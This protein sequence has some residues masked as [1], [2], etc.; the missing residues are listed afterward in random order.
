MILADT[1]V[2]L[3]PA[4]DI[5]CFFNSTLS[6]TDRIAPGWDKQ[7]GAVWLC[8]TDVAGL[9][10]IG[11]LCR[12]VKTAGRWQFSLHSREHVAKATRDDG[13]RL[14]LFPGRQIISSER[15][16][17]LALNTYWTVPDRVHSL[18][19]LVKASL[20]A[21]AMPVIPWG[22]GKWTGQ[23]GGVLRQLMAERNDFILAD[24]GNR[25]RASF[26]PSLLTTGRASGFPIWAGSD[27]LPLSRHEV[28]AGSY[29]VMADAIQ[30]N[31]DNPAASFKEL[32]RQADSCRIVGIRSAGSAFIADQWRM[33]WRQ[34]TRK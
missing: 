27:P 4:F 5:D 13:R 24:S 33:Q 19:D 12:K 34:R 23:R 15:I 30:M 7:K 2:H 8:F 21:G 20:D 31:E 26:E 14:W 10:S 11:H 17:L 1:H 28:R 32:V 29:G 22:F 9:E 3:H 25:W 18:Q 6:N 16:E